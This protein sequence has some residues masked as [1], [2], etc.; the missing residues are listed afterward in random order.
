LPEQTTR[1]ILAP[2]DPRAPAPI[3]P[4]N[5]TP[6]STASNADAGPENQA[7]SDAPNSPET[8]APTPVTKVDGNPEWVR[9]TSGKL[10]SVQFRYSVPSDEA[11]LVAKKFAQAEYK[12]D[13]WESMPLPSGYAAYGTTEELFARIKLAIA[14]QTHLSD[15]DNAL[16]TLWVFSTWFH[17]VLSIAPGL[18]ITGPAHEGDAILRAVCAFCYHPVLVAGMTG[19][20]LS[21]I[22]WDKKPTLLIFEPNLSRRLAAFLY[23]STRRGYLALRTVPGASRS[24][25]DYYG[26]KAVYAGADP[27]IRAMLQHCVHINALPASGVYSQHVATMPEEMTQKLQDQLFLYRSEHL[28]EVS[29]LELNA[30]GLSPDFNAIASALCECI[31]N[32][33]DLQNE[34]VSLLTPYSDQQIAERLDDLGTLAIGAALALCH[35][36]KDKALV[37]EIAAEVNRIQKERGERLRYSPERVGHRLRKAGLLTRRLGASGNG[38]LFDRATQVLLHDVAGAYGC[39]GSTNGNENLHCQLCTENKRVM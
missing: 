26:S 9:T 19:A 18:V 17:D 30:A 32:A 13:P 16:I 20:G 31:V 21:A 29:K 37:G 3:L 28:P 8:P 39:V 25:F 36:G 1:Q 7:A 14:E 22:Q 24:A 15:N 6:D 11:S 33:P 35:E 27:P 10:E 34:L 38:L 2:E 12:R 23:S 5:G 4:Q